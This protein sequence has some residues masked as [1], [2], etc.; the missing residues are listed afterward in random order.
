MFLPV[1]RAAE[2][3]P[4]IDELRLESLFNAAL[5]NR[6]PDRPD[7][8]ATRR[9]ADNI[10]R[11]TRYVA[12]TADDGVGRSLI[13]AKAHAGF[14]MAPEAADKR[15]E[16]KASDHRSKPGTAGGLTPEE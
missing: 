7:S 14:G 5:A 15:Q 10:N 13:R 8:T 16:S 1:R 3:A 9:F 6:N 11:Q 4:G 12:I 2:C